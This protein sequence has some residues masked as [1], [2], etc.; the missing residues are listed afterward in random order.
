MGDAA[1][2]EPHL[3]PLP[4]MPA[5]ERARDKFRRRRSEIS[6]LESL[7]VEA[8][9]LRVL[10]EVSRRFRGGGR[11]DGTHADNLCESDD[12]SD[13]R[14]FYD[15]E[16]SESGEIASRAPWSDA[17]V[18]VDALRLDRDGRRDGS[19][20]GTRDGHRCGAG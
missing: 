5:F 20:M 6:S 19:A 17:A 18:L 8:A 7:E 2:R 3:A 9:E 16:G 11:H 10:L 15:E 1:E 13:A 4:R 14:E 12:S